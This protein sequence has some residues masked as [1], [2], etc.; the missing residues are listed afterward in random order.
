MS[1]IHTKREAVAYT[2]EKGKYLNP[3]HKKYKNEIRKAVICGNCGSDYL[4]V[5]IGSEYCDLCIPCV[6]KIKSQKPK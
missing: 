2:A 1:K 3:A 6:I 5:C 4:A